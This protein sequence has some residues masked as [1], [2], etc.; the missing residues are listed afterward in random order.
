MRAGKPVPRRV[1]V[2]A[3]RE[4]AAVEEAAASHATAPTLVLDE[5][6]F[7]GSADAERRSRAFAGPGAGVIAEREQTA[8]QQRVED[9]PAPDDERA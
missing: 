8:S 7:T 1:S 6:L 4:A 3:E 9:E 2:R 5:G